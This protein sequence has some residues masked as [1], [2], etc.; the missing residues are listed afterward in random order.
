M[1]RSNFE[2]L[3]LKGEHEWDYIILDEGHLI[4]NPNCQISQLL[5]SM[6]SIHRII[7]S[8]TPVQN[9]LGEL[10]ALFDFLTDGELFGSQKDFK[11]NYEHAIVKATDREASLEEKAMGEA[12]GQNLRE[13]IKPF[14]LRREKKTLFGES[15]KEENKIIEE[16]TKKEKSNDSCKTMNDKKES[17]RE[18]LNLPKLESKRELIVWNYLSEKQIELYDS[19]LNSDE[20]SQVLNQSASP[21]A[22]LQVLNSICDHPGLLSKSTETCASLLLKQYH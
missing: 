13:V 15:Q 19:F 12:I 17:G 21:L 6:K 22:A 7:L 9:N 5:R 3:T 14:L 10:W 1:I 20:V 16:S 11:L 4:K 18:K 8:G 2:K